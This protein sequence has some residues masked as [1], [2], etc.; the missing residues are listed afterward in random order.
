[1]VFVYANLQLPIQ[2]RNPFTINHD[3]VDRI[4]FH[5]HCKTCSAIG[6]L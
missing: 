4:E 5:E 6:R 3:A 2:S 1:M